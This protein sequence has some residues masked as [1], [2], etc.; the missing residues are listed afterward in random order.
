MYAIIR[1][2]S[3]QYRVAKGDVIDVELLGS[4]PGDDVLFKD[5]LFLQTGTV[6]KVGAPTVTGCVVRG[7]MV[8]VVQGPKVFAMKYKRRKNYHRKVGH[9]QQYARVEITDIAA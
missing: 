6:S 3:K 8:G 9:R 4:E 7:K 1:T 2:G 5:V